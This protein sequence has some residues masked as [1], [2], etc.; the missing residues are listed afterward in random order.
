[1]T[2]KDGLKVFASMCGVVIEQQ[3]G[4]L[5]AIFG[6]QLRCKLSYEGYG[7]NF[8]RCIKDFEEAHLLDWAA[9]CTK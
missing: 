5:K 8:V 9:N 1:M 4:F 7:V 2:I 6:L 3:V